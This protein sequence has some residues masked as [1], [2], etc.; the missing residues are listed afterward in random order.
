MAL[1][2][3]YGT[4]DHFPDGGDL[5][6][7]LDTAGFRLRTQIASGGASATLVLT[8]AAQ[9]QP[10]DVIY[11]VSC[12][13]FH[14]VLTVATNTVTLDTALG[15][16]SD[17]SM[18][19]IYGAGLDLVS[20][21]AE[22]AEN[23]QRDTG[24]PKFINP[25]LSSET[26]TFDP[27]VN[28]EGRLFT[29]DMLSVSSV[30]FLTTTL[31]SGTDYLLQPKQNAARGLPYFWI[32]FFRRWD[33]PTPWASREGLS[34]TGV[35]GYRQYLPRDVWRACLSHAAML[36][37]P[38]LMMLR[39]RGMKAWSEADVHQDFGERPPA[40]IWGMEWKRQYDLTVARYKNSALGAGGW[41]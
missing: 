11:V 22:A 1:G 15:T 17:G 21:A 23:F 18:V 28:R 25:S 39:G 34:V 14:T 19:R 33:A 8:S 38:Q 13:E 7:F 5:S 37:L 40:L 10:G 29:G 31:T 3:G 26:R 36:A 2:L 4:G 24:R 27:P 6:H 20:L 30:S 12:G 32:D 9:V 16:A 35:W 41:Y